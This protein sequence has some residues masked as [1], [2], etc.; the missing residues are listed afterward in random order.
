[1][2]SKITILLKVWKSTKKSKESNTKIPITAIHASTV[3]SV[4]FIS[5]YPLTQPCASSKHVQATNV[6]DTL[7][8]V[9]LG[10]DYLEKHRQLKPK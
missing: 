5:V 6:G 8:D 10:K 3:Q 9:V 4:L 1:M 7:Q 2:E